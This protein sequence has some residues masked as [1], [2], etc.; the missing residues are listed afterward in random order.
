[1]ARGVHTFAA[2]SDIFKE[3]GH[4]PASD[5]NLDH[6]GLFVSVRKGYDATTFNVGYP[7]SSGGTLN[8][9]DCRRKSITKHEGR[10]NYTPLN[11][12][13]KT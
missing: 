3:Y 6:A 10:L 4:V 7:H 12:R 2:L 8:A 11:K 13:L 9:H 1:M 5:H